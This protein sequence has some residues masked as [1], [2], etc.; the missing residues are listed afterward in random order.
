[1]R[2]LSGSE[3][4]KCTDIWTRVVAD[5][6]RINEVIHFTKHQL[7]HI[8]L[9]NIG[10]GVPF[11]NVLEVRPI[12]NPK[13]YK[14]PSGSLKLLFR[15]YLSSKAENPSKIGYPDDIYDRR[16][17]PYFLENL[18]LPVTTNPS[19][20]N[21]TDIDGYNPP[22][23]VM[24]AAAIPRDANG[25]L[26]IEW[27]VKPPTAQFYPYIYVSELETLGGKDIREFN[28]MLNEGYLDGP[29]LPEQLITN[30]VYSLLPQ[31]DTNGDGKCVLR[32]KKT[33]RSTL[34]PILSAIEVYTV[35]ELSQLETNVDDVTGIK[36]VQ[37]SY[38]LSRI[39][40]QGDPCAPVQFM[41]QGLKCS[42]SDNSTPPTIISLDLS[43]SGLTGSIAEA[44]QSLP[45]LQ[46][47]DL[48]NNSLSGQVPEF[49][50]YMK[51]LLIINLS[52]NDLSGSVP[53]LLAGK[54]GMKLNVEGNPLLIVKKKGKVDM[55][56]NIVISVTVTVA[57][58]S[59]TIFLILCIWRKTRSPSV[60]VSGPP[61]VQEPD[62]QS[63]DS[64]E[65]LATRIRK[66]SFAQVTRMTNN[67]ERV[68][69]EGGFSSVY[70]GLVNGAEQVAVKVLSHSSYREF[71]A[72]IQLLLRLHHKNLLDLVGYCDQGE[73]LALIYAYMANGNLKEH[74]SGSASNNYIMNWGNR[75]K[76][77]TETAQGLEYLHSG[78]TPAIVHRDVKPT[79][80]L[81]NDQCEAKLAD[82]GLSKSFSIRDESHVLT[83]VAG[84]KGYTDPEYHGTGW[85]T[86]KSDIYSFG[87][88]LLELLT[89]QPV[90]DYGREED[91][92]GD[93]VRFKLREGD[94]SRIM[95][96]R[97]S[98]Y[99]SGSAWQYV[100][101][102]MSCLNPSS[103]DRP[104]MSQVVN[105]LK[106]CL[107]CQ[108]SMAGP[109]GSSLELS[110]AIDT[111]AGPAA[112]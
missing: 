42:H 81:L 98:D 2:S 8:C 53:L 40:W 65:H 91:H 88:L 30:P 59:F 67:F 22:Q 55:K 75:L 46:Q 12:P 61:A 48:S 47:L 108:L 24:A 10:K 109:S 13:A 63:D 70:L 95:D 16:W 100:E 93:W 101:L 66:F 86:T 31:Q 7:L 33:A 74:I 102:A 56:K 35:M 52:G 76:I 6:V 71:K 68:I 45:H 90:V 29:L 23:R 79:N 43:S 21:N 89:N 54:R 17:Y 11:I 19:M 105:V 26:D 96:P 87:V 37:G 73:T 39:T 32:L 4:I 85:L 3:R 94:M 15:L 18:W 92:I 104:T 84:T 107:A 36:D 60:E 14:N 41:W 77:A 112:R 82:F 9:V 99:H 25:T 78:C 97:L 106:E 111:K 28:M 57:V 64:S 72:E 49:L 103:A 50:A 51:S 62:D 83:K 38:N 80:V 1:M 110:M 44:I 20:I 58:T 69:G 34:P 27:T 5:D